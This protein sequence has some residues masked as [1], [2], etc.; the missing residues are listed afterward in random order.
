MAPEASKEQATKKAPS[1]RPKGD[2]ENAVVD[3]KNQSPPEDPAEVDAR[4]RALYYV[5][6]SVEV[7]AGGTGGERRA[8]KRLL[9][10]QIASAC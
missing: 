10:S 9:E 4:V 8:F 3:D 7:S 1:T 2:D 5:M 6:Q